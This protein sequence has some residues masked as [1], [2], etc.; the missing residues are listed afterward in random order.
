ME[1]HSRVREENAAGLIALSLWIVFLGG[2][3]LKELGAGFCWR[4][5]KVFD[6]ELEGPKREKAR[7]ET[8][9]VWYR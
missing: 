8:V 5:G 3:D 9:K 6:V 1:E 7:E 4:K 2:L